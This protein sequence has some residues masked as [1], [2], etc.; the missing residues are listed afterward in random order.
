MAN[1]E[2]KPAKPS[3]KGPLILGLLLALTGAAAGFFLSSNKM[4][5][6]I[7]SPNAVALDTAATLQTA[8]TVIE[9]PMPESPSFVSVP[10]L[11]I[12]LGVGSTSRHL[13]FAATLE[14]TPGMAQHVEAVMPRI[15]DVL[16]GYLRAVE[17]AD[18]DDPA[19]LT[20]LRKQMLRR[21]QLVTEPGQISDLLISEFILD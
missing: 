7:S 6:F 9:Q 15:I 16:N 21:V 8:P 5:P 10:P 20:R 17:T 3:M 1:V 11:L 12:S 14:T 18:F 2:T 4:L 13:R 19:I